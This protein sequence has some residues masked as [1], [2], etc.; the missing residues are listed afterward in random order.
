[1]LNQSADLDR[2]FHALADPT[3]RAFVE[4]LADGP[5][6]VSD[7]A[8]PLAMSLPSVVQH[9]Q[10][11]EASGLI[12]SRKVG[13]VRTCWVAEDS[14]RQAERWLADQRRAWEARLDRLEA[15]L[16]EDHTPTKDQGDQT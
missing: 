11:L 7:L 14:M 9:L 2:L 13:R 16:T 8:R 12:Q 15:F 4:R 1:M 3:R 5:A 10:V 6:T